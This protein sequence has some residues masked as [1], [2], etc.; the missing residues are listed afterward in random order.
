MVYVDGPALERL[1]DDAERLG[2][3]N[4][5]LLKELDKQGE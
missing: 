4:T 1:C 2:K 5:W 3:Y